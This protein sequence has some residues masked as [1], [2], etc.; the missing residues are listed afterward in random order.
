MLTYYRYEERSRK[1]AASQLFGGQLVESQCTDSVR[2]RV[3]SEDFPWG[4]FV[5]AS[6]VF[7]GKF[8]K[9]TWESLQSG[10]FFQTS[11]EW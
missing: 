9:I 1:F 6:G 11:P 4:I 10:E 3:Y 2:Y 8:L 5:Q 7:V